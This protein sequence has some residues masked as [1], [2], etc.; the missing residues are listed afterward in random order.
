MGRRRS[1]TAVADRM[2]ITAWNDMQPELGYRARRLCSGNPDLA[3]DLLAD[4]AVKALVFMRR[5]PEAITDARGFLFVVL[6]HVFLDAT[7]RGRARR[8]LDH[9]TDPHPKIDAAADSGPSTLQHAEL[10]Q[11]LERLDRAVAAMSAE[12]QRLFAFRFVDDLPY[13]VIADRLGINP[14]LARKRIELLR[15]QLRIT[16]GTRVA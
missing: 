2:F 1:E 4:T 9:A 5:S 11:S 12:Q 6:R 7:R 13:Q 8:A 3:E 16:V 10:R 14:P 15:K